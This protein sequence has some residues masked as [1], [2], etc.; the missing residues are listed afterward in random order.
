MVALGND[1]DMS[2]PMHPTRVRLIETVAAMLDEKTPREITSEE[3]LAVS[4]IS[5][6][7]LYHHFEDFQDLMAAAQVARFSKQVDLSIEALTAALTGSRTSE[8][9]I[10]GLRRIT[11]ATQSGRSMKSRIERVT[12][13]SHA[14][15]DARMRAQLGKEQARM[16]E[17]LTDLIRETQERG[18]YAKDF[19]PRA[20][21]VLIQA[22]TLGKVVDDVVETPMDPD[23]WIDLIMRLIER[24][25]MAPAAKPSGRKASKSG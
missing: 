25:F 1:E 7:S 21:A 14:G 8:E 22:Y 3:V 19:D 9:F 18:L 2:A 6:G 24:V 20:A 11:I 12:T 13:L 16:T 23:A 15:A 17:A 4:G 5:R 10:E